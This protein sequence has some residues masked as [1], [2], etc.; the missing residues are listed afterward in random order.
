M[1]LSLLFVVAAVNSAIAKPLYVRSPIPQSASGGSVNSVI[2]GAIQ[3][4]PSILKGNITA[5]MQSMSSIFGGAASFTPN[6]LADLYNA[7]KGILTSSTSKDSLESSS[8]FNSMLSWASYLI[9]SQAGKVKT[10]QGKMRTD[11]K[12]SIIQ[13]GPYDLPAYKVCISA[14]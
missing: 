6:F 2:D 4:A 7:N 8:S 10:V 14:L 1:K 11:S 3:F 13:Y 9:P 5:L 12:L